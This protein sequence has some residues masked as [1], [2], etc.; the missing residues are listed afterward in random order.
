MTSTTGHP[1][2][3]PTREPSLMVPA[4]EVEAAEA[5]RRTEVAL[6]EARREELLLPPVPAER[7]QALEAEARRRID[8]RL[9]TRRKQ[10]RL[11]SGGDSST[12][13]LAPGQ[14]R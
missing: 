12:H 3:D 4:A 10:R 6:E 8:E 13:G 7:L 1:H 5:A 11:L 2:S 14:P 9:A